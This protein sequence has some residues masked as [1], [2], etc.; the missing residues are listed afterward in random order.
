[1]NFNFFLYVEF[2]LV[3]FA[4]VIFFVYYPAKNL[5]FRLDEWYNMPK[6]CAY[7]NSK[8]LYEKMKLLFFDIWGENK[9]FHMHPISLSTLF[10]K[11]KFLG[12]NFPRHLY[13]SLS[14]HLLNYFLLYLVSLKITGNSY[15]AIISAILFGFSPLISDTIF[16]PG[17]FA[18]ILVTSFTLLSILFNP[19]FGTSEVSNIL[20]ILFNL[21]SPFVFELG[22]ITP[23]FSILILTIYNHLN[24]YNYVLLIIVIFLP[25]LLRILYRSKGH[26]AELMKKRNILDIFL[27]AIEGLFK[28]AIGIFSCSFNSVV[29]DHVYVRQPTKNITTFVAFSF[30]LI[31]FIS[32]VLFFIDKRVLLELKSLLFVLMCIATIPFIMVYMYYPIEGLSHFRELDKIAIQL[33]RYFYLPTA[34]VSIIISTVL[35]NSI[36]VLCSFFIVLI[37]SS[38]CMVQIRNSY[39]LILPHTN[40]IKKRLSEFNETGFLKSRSTKN[41]FDYRLDCFFNIETVFA[42]NKLTNPSEAEFFL[43][44]TQDI[45]KKGETLFSEGNVNEAKIIFLKIIQYTTSY[46]EA[47]NN[48]AII[49][50]MNNNKRMA[51]VFLSIA[52]NHDP[53]NKEILLNFVNVAL[54]LQQ[55]LLIKIKLYDFLLRHPDHKDIVDLYNSINFPDISLEFID[56][57]TSVSQIELPNTEQIC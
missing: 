8:N 51:F 3:L 45:L 23:L 30:F 13:L 48:L 53:D 39:K 25:F 9:I 38:L 54:S 15:V 56:K 16:M 17:Y 1:M 5:F 41:I 7:F 35:V 36:G 42:F 4:V 55:H 18:F 19:V 44:N 21:L 24:L 52:T 33:S 27:I 34:L 26:D 20:F 29:A 11:F 40:D 43:K 12:T 46:S 49:E 31:C 32:L 28:T 6:I 50:L 14:F 10:Y 2:Y 22:I 37:S 47:Y 57:R